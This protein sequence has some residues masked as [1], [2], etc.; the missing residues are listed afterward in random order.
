MV[1]ARDV[2]GLDASLYMARSG[3]LPGFD[4]EQR[5]FEDAVDFIPTYYIG[6]NEIGFRD[7]VWGDCLIENEGYDR[8]WF[9]LV[10]N[11]LVRRSA[12]IEQLSLGPELSTIPNTGYFSRWEHIWGSVAFVRNMLDKNDWGLDERQK[13]ILQLRTFLSDLGHTA[14][15]HLG[16]WMFQGKGGAESQHDDEL[17]HLLEVS[18]IGDILREYDIA[19]EEVVFPDVADWIEAPS[20]DLCVDRVDYSL[21]EINRWQ[22]LIT[23]VWNL[24]YP[25]LFSVT[26]Q[27][28][29][30]MSNENAARQF[31]RAFALLSTEHWGEPA[32]RLQLHLLEEMVKRTFTGEHDIMGDPYFLQRAHPRDFMYAID[33]DFLANIQTGDHFMATMRELAYSIGRQQRRIFVTSRKSGLNSFLEGRTNTFPRPGEKLDGWHG[34][35]PQ[36]ANNL[37]IIP[38]ISAAD[39]ADF[40]QNPYTIDIFLPPLKPRRVDPKFIGENGT[41]KRLSEQDPDVATIEQQQLSIMQQAYVARVLVA[42]EH[43]KIIKDGLRQSQDRWPE[44]LRL[45]RMDQ[46]EFTRILGRAAM[47]GMGKRMVDIRRGR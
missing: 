9:K 45:P 43:R 21:R 27:G 4:M 42:S 41:I 2:E 29:L 3:S 10:D 22:K 36:H 44:L 40:D 1:R 8:I 37:E 34:D 24:K 46:G 5:S 39:V 14:F 15:S 16:D 23:G 47:V 25:D 35:L 26:E 12:A 30:V 11:D 7:P 28:E 38:V 17:A 33:D 6:P 32:H 18:G 31:Q 19:V 20:P 13:I